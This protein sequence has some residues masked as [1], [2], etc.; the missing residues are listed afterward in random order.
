MF[1]ID[2]L[3]SDES[4][5]DSVRIG[6]QRWTTNSIEPAVSY[7]SY[8]LAARSRILVHATCHGRVPGPNSQPTNT[9]TAKVSKTWSC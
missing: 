4:E 2:L 3:E 1:G 5:I 8:F 7:I 6:K 9:S